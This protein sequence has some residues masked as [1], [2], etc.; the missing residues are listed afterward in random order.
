MTPS[1]TLIRFPTHH[2]RILVT[3]DQ[4]HL[5]KFNN[6]GCD[7]ETFSADDSLNASDYIIDPLPQI[8]Y[9][10]KFPDDSE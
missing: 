10:V 5:F 3:E 8:H 2:V 1:K 7:F 4:I 6:H 9:Q